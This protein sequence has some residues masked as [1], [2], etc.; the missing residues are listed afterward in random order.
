MPSKPRIPAELKRSPTGRWMVVQWVEAL[1][2]AQRG[3]DGP[4]ERGTLLLL[5]TDSRGL[6]RA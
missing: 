4:M 5:D 6:T 3:D 2:R 1:T